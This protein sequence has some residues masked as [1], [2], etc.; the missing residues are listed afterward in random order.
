MEITV[1]QAQGRVPVTVLQPHG[2]LDAS[3]YRDLIAKAQEAHDSGARDI[4]L[5]LSDVP[6]MSSAGL[7]ALHRI[8]VMLRGEK[9]P[10]SGSGWEDFRAIDRDL[11]QGLQQ[12]IKLLQPQ[13][14][15]DKVLDMVGFKKL[16][17]IYTDQEAAIASF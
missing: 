11:D 14:A 5:D 10:D 13:P 2:E 6:H 12:H 8:T 7:V 15:V 17:G 9:Q 4:L 1:Y 16:F 3:N